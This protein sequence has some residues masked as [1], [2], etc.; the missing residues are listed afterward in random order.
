MTTRQRASRVL[1]PLLG[2]TALVVV[3]DTVGRSGVVGPSWPPLTDV[4]AYIVDPGHRAILTTALGST[5]RSA[6]LGGAIGGLAG[7]ALAVVAR[8]VPISRPGLDRF[9][10]ILDA[11]PAIAIA[12]VVAVSLGR[13]ATPA[14]LPGIIVGFILYVAASSG[15]SAASAGHADVFHAFGARRTTRLI[16]LDLPGAM[17]AVF[18]GLVL[19]AP[20]MITGATI[21][22]WFGA[23][24]G[25][26]VLLVSAMQNYQVTLL[27]AAALLCVLCS[28]V[29]YVL[30]RAAHGAIVRRFS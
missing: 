22:E 29:L 3:I 25:L 17:P 5:L 1:A 12:P 9:A 15:L 26:G 16:A 21:G 8:V 24:S 18:D 28:L 2:S 30:A 14:L 11:A 23:P 10:A 4:L 13:E 20:A 7:V 27:W 6:L 19:A